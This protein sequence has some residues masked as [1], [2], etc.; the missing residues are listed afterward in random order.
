MDVFNMILYI[1]NMVETPGGIILLFIVNRVLMVS[2]GQ[3]YW[4]YGFMILY[5]LYAGT[6]VVLM[7]KNNFPYEGDIISSELKLDDLKKKEGGMNSD[8]LIDLSKKVSRTPSALLF[9]I[10]V[11]YILLLFVVRT[12]KLDGVDIK[13]F[14]I[15]NQDEPEGKE[16]SWRILGV[17][18]VFLIISVYF[19]VG[20][21]RLFIRKSQKMDVSART[22]DS[23]KSILKNNKMCN[24][25]MFYW[26][27]SLT[28][29]IFW[30]AIV[31][32]LTSYGSI[33]IYGTL[34]SI[35]VLFYF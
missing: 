31:S 24:I 19:L 16:V 28:V 25:W 7:A 13:P 20:L 14:R 18:S 3:Q 12:I 15:Y 8:K 5:L 6:F 17:L 33:F 32:W 9:L 10:T 27:F 1:S 26:L 30:S 29:C 2:L 22:S 4:I 34:S 23:M 35:S 21:W 11:L